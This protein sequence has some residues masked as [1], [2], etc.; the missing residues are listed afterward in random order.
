[1]LTLCFSKIN[2]V[3]TWANYIKHKL[4]IE[5]LYL[6]PE[7][8]FQIYFR[9]VDAGNISLPFG[10]LPEDRFAIKNFKS[11]IRGRCRRQTIVYN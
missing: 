8:L 4:D 3:R 6:E 5:N 9:P 11:L 7:P 10:I 1:M 2:E